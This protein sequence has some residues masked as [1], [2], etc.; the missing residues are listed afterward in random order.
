MPGHPEGGGLLSYVQD[1]LLIGWKPW[2]FYFDHLKDYLSFEKSNGLI[3][4]LEAYS[5]HYEKPKV[6]MSEL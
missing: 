3:R 1:G 6:D 2:F 5:W 4:S